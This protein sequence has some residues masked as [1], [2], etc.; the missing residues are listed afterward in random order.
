MPNEG[1]TNGV[2]VADNDPVLRSILRSVIET[3]GFRVFQA[4]NGIEAVDLAT[5]MVARLVILDFKMPRLDG[6]SA[7]HEMRLLPG[8]ASVPIVMLTAYDDEATRAAASRAGA[9]RFLTKPFRTAE[10][11]RTI[12]PLIGAAPLDGDR[13]AAEPTSHVWKPRTEPAPAY[14]ERQ[15]FAE[16]RQVL[17]IYRR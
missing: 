17:N 16:A 4:V 6:L 8:Y 5:R 11:L 3:T 12:R 10:L 7:C 13:D 1:L 15:E 9:T 2:I 14:G